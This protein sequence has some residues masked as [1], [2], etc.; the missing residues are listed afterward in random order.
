MLKCSRK[1]DL[2]R[3]KKGKKK[4]KRECQSFDVCPRQHSYNFCYLMIASVRGILIAKLV[5]R[6]KH[7]F[8][9]IL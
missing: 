7:K 1:Y 8:E 9:P 6:Y 3:K 5:L 4:K 2:A